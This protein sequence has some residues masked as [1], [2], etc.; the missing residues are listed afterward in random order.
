[1]TT[2]RDL[3]GVQ[4]CGIASDSVAEFMGFRRR[5]CL[6]FGGNYGDDDA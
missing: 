1:M 5:I 2:T 3:A 4:N 6:R